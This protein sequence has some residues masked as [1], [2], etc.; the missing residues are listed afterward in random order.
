[1]ALR[2][3]SGSA[4][5]AAVAIC[6]LAALCPNAAK[7]ADQAPVGKIVA[8]DGEAWVQSPG[9]AQHALAC[10]DTLAEGDVLVTGPGARAAIQA[11][12]VFAQVAGGSQVR[13]THGPGGAPKL[14]VEK[15]HA[16]VRRLDLAS[17]RKGGGR[18]APPGEC[19]PAAPPVAA[20]PVPLDR[21]IGSPV[22]RFNPT[23]VAAAPPGPVGP[24]PQPPKVIDP[25]AVAAG[26]CFAPPTPIPT[27]TT[28]RTGVLE[29]A[30]VPRLPPG[31]RP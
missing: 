10:G 16:Y 19:A 14:D 6:A 3:R 15:G 13:L 23:D 25:C 8:L 28:V 17:L 18:I 21:L 7:A 2:S 30:P 26:V 11:G 12:D 20:A 24:G 29:Q 27:P 22:E 1:M 31:V 5:L 4:V 9:L